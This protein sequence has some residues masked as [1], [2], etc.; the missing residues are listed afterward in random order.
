VGAA[1]QNEIFA[2]DLRAAEAAVMATTQRLTAELAFSDPPGSPAWRRLPSWAVVG[3]GDKAA[4]TDV[5][6]SLAQR[7]GS[8]ITEA[9]S[10]HVI[11]VS[12]SQAVT[13]VVLEAVA[14]VGSA[15]EH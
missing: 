15:S 3:T 12:Q 10:S 9:D 1:R 8:T 14:S 11:M 13:D 5:I 2:A 6:R 7:A 4:G